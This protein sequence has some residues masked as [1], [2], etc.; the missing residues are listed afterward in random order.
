MARID[1]GAV[2]EPSKSG[3]TGPKSGAASSGAGKAAGGLAS[4][5]ASGGGMA[6]DQKVKLAAAVGVLAIALGAIAWNFWPESAPGA[7]SGASASAGSSG[8]D[9]GGGGT[10]V[11]P[12]QLSDDEIRK[13]N[14]DP[15]H[16]RG[17]LRAAPK[18]PGTQPPR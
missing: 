2:S 8:G 13:L 7:G 6:K 3:A 10:V 18:Q 11:Q 4:K 5:A 12:R 1:L 15:K 16:R 9:A 14:E 17:G